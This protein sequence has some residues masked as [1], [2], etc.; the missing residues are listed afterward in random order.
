MPRFTIDGSPIHI[1]YG[2]NEE[3]ICGIFLSVYDTRLEWDE[4]ATDQVNDVAKSVGICDGAGSYFNLHTGLNGFGKKVTRETIRTYLL[5]YG[6][7]NK[8]IDDLFNWTCGKPIGLTCTVCYKENTK[9]CAKCHQFYYCSK[10]CQVGDWSD[11]KMICNNSSSPVGNTLSLVCSPVEEK[12]SV[13]LKKTKNKCSKCNQTY[14]CS[15]EC[16]KKEWLIHKLVCD[17]LPFPKKIN[18]PNKNVYAFYLSENSEKVELV[19]VEIKRKYDE[20]DYFEV[21]ELNSFLGNDTR[22]LSY[23]SRNPYNKSRIMKDTL[24]ICYRDNFFNDGS[25]I[26]K[27]VQKMTNGLNPHDWRGSV[28]IM[29]TLGTNLQ[30]NSSYLDIELKDMTDVYDFFFG[31]GRKY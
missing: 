21:A 25:K 3:F 8:R 16:L 13:C 22:G 27:V 10:E 14:Y 31:Y 29:K 5:R 19:Q 11:H 18:E 9:V 17:A 2:V 28:V 6:V 24:L 30:S 15:K 12:C 1:V 20:D 4:N 7:T 26:N 23:M